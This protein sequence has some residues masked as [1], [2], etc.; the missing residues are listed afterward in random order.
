MGKKK[1]PISNFYFRQCFA[2]HPFLQLSVHHWLCKKYM[3]SEVTATYTLFY[4]REQRSPNSPKVPRVHGSGGC[5][6]ASY[7]IA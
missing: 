4:K 1:S 7:N 2:L 6:S 3:S 5:F